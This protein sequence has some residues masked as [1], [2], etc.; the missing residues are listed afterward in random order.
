[1]NTDKDSN[2]NPVAAALPRAW[3]RWTMAAALAVAGGTALASYANGLPAVHGHHGH[4]AMSPQAMQAHVDKMVE[5]CAA[6]ASADQKA[7]ITAIAQ[8]AIADLGPT[9]RQFRDEHARA[10]ALLAAPTI[11]RAALEQWRAAQMQRMDLMSRRVQ[12]ALEDGAE[13]LTPEQ[14]TACAGRLGASMH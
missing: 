6:D 8:S 4:M 9:H 3:R 5:L 13:L 1:M 14:R 7:R 10:H 12:A 11:D 2:A